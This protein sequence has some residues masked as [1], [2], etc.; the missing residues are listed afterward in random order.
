MSVTTDLNTLWDEKEQRDAAFEARALLENFRS[1]MVETHEALNVI[2]N[3]GQFGTIPVDIR[4][5]LN[6]AWTALKDCQTVLEG[7]EIVEALD[8]VQP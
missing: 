6:D 8:W 5:T 4:N 1:V 2:K 7:A 3:S